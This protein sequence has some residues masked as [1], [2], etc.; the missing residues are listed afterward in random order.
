MKG[1]RS[2]KH[3]NARATIVSD[4]I[5]TMVS[6]ALSQFLL[7]LLVSFSVIATTSWW[8]TLICPLI[9]GLLLRKYIVFETL[10]MV[11]VIESSLGMW[12]WF[13]EI[14]QNSVFLGALPLH[15]LQHMTVLTEKHKITA[16]LSVLEN[17]EMNS[18]SIAGKS[19]ESTDWKKADVSHVQIIVQD[20]NPPTCK[21]L[22]EGADWIN[23]VRTCF[24]FYTTEL[25]YF[26]V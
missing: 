9:Y 3:K 7:V 1:T 18:N 16:V 13:N 2:T 25:I 6:S 4:G 15:S 23:D 21:L 20:F 14:E 10:L 11:H 26:C 22:D 24:P 8:S 12:S 19:V 17:F 5:R